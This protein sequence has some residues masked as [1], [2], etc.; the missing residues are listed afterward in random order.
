MKNFL[1]IGARG[2]GKT[3]FVKNNFFNLNR[4]V[5]VNDINK[6]YGSNYLNLDLFIKKCESA[7]NSV[8]IF[9]EATVFFNN[10]GHNRKITEILVRSRHTN[11]ICV[12]VFHSVRAVPIYILDL[13]NY[14]VLFNTSDSSEVILK[15]FDNYKQITD[16][17]LQQKNVDK[18]IE[19]F[20]P[21]IFKL[22]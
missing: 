8:L 3:T 16:F 18:K 9:E 7:R 4:N 6:E 14:V 22:I 20:K 15:K 2:Q 11:N 12:F 13:M 21:K 10:R 19:K 5:L 1:V 17:F